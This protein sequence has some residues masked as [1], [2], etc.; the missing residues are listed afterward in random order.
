MIVRPIGIET[1]LIALTITGWWRVRW[2]LM[3]PGDG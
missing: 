1:V 3:G 2:G